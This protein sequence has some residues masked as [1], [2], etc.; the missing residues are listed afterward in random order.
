[1]APETM[2]EKLQ[3]ALDLA[4]MGIALMR[5]NLRRANPDASDEEVDRLLDDW[6]GSRPGAVLGDCPGRVRTVPSE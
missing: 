1:M 3:G 4:D 2:G 6:L 5:Q